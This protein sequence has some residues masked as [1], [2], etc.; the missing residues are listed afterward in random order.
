MTN[1]EL[2]R[3]VA[4]EW[5]RPM[6]RESKSDADA[7]DYFAS[8]DQPKS[9]LITYAFGAMVTSAMVMF[10]ASL[11]VMLAEESTAWALGFALTACVLLFVATL[12]GTLAK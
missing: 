1:E 3:I 4:D 11:T 2:S 8:Q 10:V 7:F 6:I 9:E 5:S 12:V